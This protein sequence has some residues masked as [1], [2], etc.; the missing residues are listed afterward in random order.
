LCDHFPERQEEAF[1]AAFKYAEFGGYEDITALPTYAD[2]L[3]AGKRRKKSGK[4]WRWS[5]KKPASEAELLGLEAQFGALPKDYRKFLATT[6]ASELWVQLSDHSGEFCFYPP[7]ELATQRDN[8]VNFIM[9]FEKDEN[10]VADYFRQEYGVSLRHLV[11]VAQPA[12]YS[13]CLLIHLGEGERF[14]WCFHWDHDDAW[15]LEQPTSSFDAALK[16]LT[17][18]I[19]K[20][21]TEMLGFLGVYL[22]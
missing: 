8:L 18:G 11:P 4:G 16:A 5:G 3:A 21:N 2:Y 17:G 15:E 19:E 9:R 14:G 7:S 20:R 12:Q 22:D 1:D 13:R 10:K 6:G